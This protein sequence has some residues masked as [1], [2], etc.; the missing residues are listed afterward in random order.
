[1]GDNGEWADGNDSAADGNGKW[2]DVDISA[3]GGS[4]ES[5]GGDAMADDDGNGKWIDVDISAVG[6]SGESAGGDAMAF[7]GSATVA[8]GIG[9]ASA[10][11]AAE[12]SAD[13][14]IGKVRM[15]LYDWLQCIV[16][17]IICGL[18][19]FIFLGRTIGVD[20]RSMLQT[21]HNKDRVIMSNLFYSPKYGDIIVFQPQTD[22]FG[23]TPLVKRVIAVAG[24]TVDI[25]FDTGDVFIDGVALDEPYINEPTHSRI[26]FM[27]PV[28][29]PEGHVFVMGDNRNS[30]S[31]SRDD[32]VGM[33]DTRYVLGK[34][35]FI[36][37]PGAD[38]ETPRDWSRIGVP[39]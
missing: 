3:A 17:A 38:K 29:V 36:L 32:R 28:T 12:K 22:S 5:A 8:G 2:I 34:V 23:G 11:E 15:E 25:N 14:E 7:G 16:S 30:S 13:G 33:V 6:S 9:Q 24:Q 20:G 4:G 19:L 37:M 31:D 1:M 26:N 21:L 27:G 39:R 35:L 10:E 18:F